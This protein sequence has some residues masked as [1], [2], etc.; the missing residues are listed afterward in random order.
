MLVRSQL[1]CYHPDLPKLV[2]DLKTRATSP[3]RFNIEK[4]KKYIPYSINVVKGKTN[5]YE[6]EFYDMIRGTFIK[7]SFQARLGI[8]DGIFV[9]YHNTQNIF[10]FEYIPLGEIDKA[11][12]ETKATA[13]L[14]FQ[15]SLSSLQAVLN[16]IIS[17][18]EN[19]DNLLMEVK[20][21]WE[22]SE[23]Q[24]YI[25]PI[26]KHNIIS[27]TNSKLFVLKLEKVIGDKVVHGPILV[28]NKDNVK[29]YHNIFQAKERTRY[30]V[31]AD[32]ADL[33]LEDRKKKKF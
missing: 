3:I 18:F 7:Y 6:R 5:S 31:G 4:F 24:F 28:D 14:S 30:A 19:E 13:E 20:T 8:M 25:Q 17:E 32:V 29:I 15:M 26:S 33:V 2:F 10:G 1:D 27:S 23:T 11:I 21:I 9:T 16:D 12:Y 22:S